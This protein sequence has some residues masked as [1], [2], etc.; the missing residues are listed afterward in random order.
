MDQN[1]RFSSSKT[2]TARQY[3]FQKLTQF[4]MWNSV[5]DAPLSDRDSFPLKI[6]VFLHFSWR[7]LFWTKRGV[8]PLENPDWQQYSFLKDTQYSQGNN[9]LHAPASN[10]HGFI[11]GDTCVSSTQVNRPIRK[12]NAFLNFVIPDWQVVFLLKTNSVLT[13]KQCATCSSF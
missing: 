6:P 7:G 12:K 1:E 5:L 2:L 10:F 3:S 4:S 13:E 8:L 9:V 11:S